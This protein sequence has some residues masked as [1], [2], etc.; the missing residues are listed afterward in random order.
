MLIPL[1]TFLVA[2]VF[3]FMLSYFASFSPW[4]MSSLAPPVMLAAC[5]AFS[6]DY[7]LFQLTRYKQELEAGRTPQIAVKNT[8]T[9]SGHIVIVSG[10]AIA[11]C[12]FCVALC[13]FAVVST[14]GIG[15]GLMLIGVILVNI[16]LLPALLL[17]GDGF[18][19]DRYVRRGNLISKNIHPDLYEKV[20]SK[21][22]SCIGCRCWCCNAEITSHQEIE[23]E[24]HTISLQKVLFNNQDQIEK[25]SLEI[26]QQKKKTIEL[27]QAGFL[28]D[29]NVI[30]KNEIDSPQEPC[31]AASLDNVEIKGVDEIEETIHHRNQRKS[32]F[33]R[34]SSS[35]TKK[36]PSIIIIS[37]VFL[38]LVP[39]IILITLY[40]Q[41]TVNIHQIF[42]M[43]SQ[44]V[45]DYDYITETFPIGLIG[46]FS[47]LINTELETIEEDGA[48]EFMNNLID[49]LIDVANGDIDPLEVDGIS[50]L[51]GEKLTVE[52]SQE[53]LNGGLHPLGPTYRFLYQSIVSADSQGTIVNI[54]LSIDPYGNEAEDLLPILRKTIDD[55]NSKS[56]Y[57]YS[58]YLLGGIT[59]LVDC[60]DFVYAHVPL[61]LIATFSIIILIVILTFKTVSMPIIVVGTIAITLVF[62]FGL[63]SLIFTSGFFSW[64]PN[65]DGIDAIYW[66]D[67][68]LC[69]SIVSC[70]AMD[71]N[72]F[73]CMRV[74]ELRKKGYG[75]KA[76]VTRAQYTSGSTIA[77]AA[78]IMAVAFTGLLQSRVMM[79]VEFGFMLAFAVLFD[80]LVMRT[81]FVPAILTLLGD[82]GWWPMKA[83]DATKDAFVE[84]EEAMC[85]DSSELSP[86][87]KLNDADQSEVGT[88]SEI[89]GDQI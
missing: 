21:F 13:D 48:F 20:Q 28:I 4:G 86:L 19:S 85:S 38:I 32:Y 17:V 88:T 41:S 15:T 5:V 31:S 72:T 51:S 35:I 9:Y 83:L 8:V 52:K 25:L 42:P 33:F 73:F 63:T 30:E 82:I 34:M 68:I 53:L 27:C 89:I 81:F 76:S 29:E 57:I 71:Y 67:S 18:F 1:C 64:L 10:L 16:T 69:L 56:N 87:L 47:L 65:L 24:S 62:I 43:N 46:P 78:I 59:D 26:K 36:G 70:L 39:C 50:Y 61:M 14:I 60:V 12:F 22:I 3:G 40:F 54:M 79:M 84:E 2:M 80:A 44:F 11:V 23:L 74:Y 6:L 7:C 66:A 55:H 77:Y 75:N 45:S 37:V 58:A 49:D